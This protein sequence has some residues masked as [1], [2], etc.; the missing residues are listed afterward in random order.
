[1]VKV[2]FQKS[3]MVK[4]NKYKSDKISLKSVL[5]SMSI[6]VSDSDRNEAIKTLMM[7]GWIR[8]TMYAM[9]VA[10]RRDNWNFGS[11]EV[12]EIVFF[13]LDWLGS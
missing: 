3:K 9:R 10:K 11:E 7:I 6:L 5:H 1:M 2:H 12:E 13:F 8:T 4:N